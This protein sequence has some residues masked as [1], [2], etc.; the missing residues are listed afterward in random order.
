MEVKLTELTAEENDKMKQSIAK[1]Y[2]TGIDAS[3]IEKVNIDKS[4][5]VVVFDCGFLTLCASL[6]KDCK[7]IR[8][9]SI[10]ILD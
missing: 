4:N 5:R 8:K 9:H 6:T 10:I 3:D 7:S 1:A 2:G